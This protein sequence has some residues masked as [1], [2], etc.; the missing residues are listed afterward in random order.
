VRAER[1]ALAAVVALSACATLTRPEGDGGWSAERR[2][3]ELA[4]RATAARVVLEPAPEPTPSPDEPLDLSEAIVLA[5]R[6]DRRIAQAEKSVGGAAARVRDARGRLL[7]QTIGS[8]RYTW[9]T[10]TQTV[11]VP[12]PIAP[13]GVTPGIVLR[14]EDVGVLNGTV[15][16]PIDLSGEITHALASA[17][18]GYRGE[19]ARLWATTL[20]QQVEVIRSYFQLLEAE[21]LRDVTDQTIRVQRAQLGNAQSRFDAGRLTKNELLVVQV[22]VS[23]AEQQRRQRTLAID[24]ARWSLNQLIGRPVNAP[25]VVRDV[26]RAPDVPPIDEALRAAYAN[27]PALVALVEE[28]Q[29]LEEQT[30]S[31]ERSR[32][33]RVSAGG[34]ID[35]SS[36]DIVQPQEMG[37]GFVGFT[38][39]LGTDT[40]R[41]AQIA[42]A[43][44]RAEAN[45]I[46]LEAELRELEE[47]VRST[48]R[49]TE[50]RLAAL[51]SAEAAVGQ[52][53]E[54]LRIR[55][56]QFE[57]GRAQSEDV[58]DAEAILA[59]E[60][61]TLATALYQAQTRRAELQRLLGLPLDAVLDPGA[62]AS[63]AEK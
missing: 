58:L 54:N 38:W 12:L 51:A 29:R 55:Q 4:R 27:N 1:C 28:Q 34:A 21:R 31:L 18:A 11:S 47:A 23:N 7:P 62:A 52:A 44:I 15:T 25:T 22:A 8:G 17:Q 3:E 46:A 42:E 30:R 14:E 56:Q 24:R 43:R 9:Y 59:A 63:V 60:R 40:R 35:Y 39:D 6:H 45:A 20:A 10:D 41:E 32:F 37:S 50:E 16:L 13:P 53:E 33:P 19:R 2:R 49:A 57:A 5:A 26:R 48:Q 36:S 61:A